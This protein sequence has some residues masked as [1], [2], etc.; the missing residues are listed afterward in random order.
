MGLASALLLLLG[1]CAA[2]GQPTLLNADQ[3]LDNLFKQF[4]G[5]L[6]ACPDLHQLRL[7]TRNDVRWLKTRLRGTKVDRQYVA[8]LA[9]LSDMVRKSARNANVNGACE[10]LRLVAADLHV[11]RQDKTW[12]DGK[13][14][15]AGYLPAIASPRSRNGS[16]DSAVLRAGPFRFPASM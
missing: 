1:E 2:F 7:S 16:R 9:D 11:K 4:G 13:F 3:A 5:G 15:R 12:P 10:A 6:P 14:I 8:S